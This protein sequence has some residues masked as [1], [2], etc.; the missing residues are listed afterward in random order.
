MNR[1][2][3]I[4]DRNIFLQD[5]FQIQPTFDVSVHQE[6]K[7]KPVK[8]H[9]HVMSIFMCSSINDLILYYCSSLWR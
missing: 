2:V 1:L 5:V 9:L 4:F 6:P 3:F 7:G 8:K